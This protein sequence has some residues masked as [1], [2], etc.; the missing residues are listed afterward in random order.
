MSIGFYLGDLFSSIPHQIVI[1]FISMIPVVELR[2]AI[3]VALTLYQMDVC[4]SFA[5]S[6]IGNIIPVFFIF[7]LLRPIS[8]FLSP[9]H[10]L[11]E[12][13]F[14]YVFS[15]AEEKGR[16][17]IQKYKSLALT[18]FVAVPFPLT[19]AWTGTAIAIVFGI[20]FKKAFPAILAGVMIAG[21]IVTALTQAGLSVWDAIS[22]L[23][24][25]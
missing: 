5:L 13:F 4:S 12:N 6:V 22:I 24:Q 19:G 17:N 1:L 15:R 11:F 9:K 2:G 21:V 18:A 10:K 3:P 23:F 20:P 14:N 16:T 8:D 25:F 7:Y